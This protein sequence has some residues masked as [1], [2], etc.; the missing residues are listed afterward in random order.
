MIY[1]E[2]RHRKTDREEILSRCFNGM[3][4]EL[5]R[6]CAR[7]RAATGKSPARN[8]VRAL[9]RRERERPEPT[10]MHRHFERLEMTSFTTVILERDCRTGYPPFTRTCRPSDL[11]GVTQRLRLTSSNSFRGAKSQNNHGDRHCFGARAGTRAA[12]IKK[13]GG[14]ATR[15]L[16]Y[17]QYR[18]LTP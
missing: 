12:P 13:T 1:S 9:S 16:L 6:S 8:T 11:A 5:G 10:L 4:L 15:R 14:L 3:R 7:S 2:S 18:P 17:W